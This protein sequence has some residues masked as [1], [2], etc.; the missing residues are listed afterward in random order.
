MQNNLGYD[1]IKTNQRRFLCPV[2]SKHTLLFLFPET[3][4]KNLPLKCKRCGQ[5]S[6]VNISP[7]PEL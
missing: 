7:E 4:V 6:V 3:E 1:K 2:C 5:I